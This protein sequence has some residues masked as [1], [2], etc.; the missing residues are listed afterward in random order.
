MFTSKLPNKTSNHCQKITTFSKLLVSVI[1]CNRWQHWHL[2]RLPRLRGS[3]PR[4]WCIVGRDVPSRMLC[5]TS[6]C[7]SGLCCNLC[8]RKSPVCKSHEKV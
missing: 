5:C 1:A 4:E 6:D 8:L 2:P 3:R 7:L